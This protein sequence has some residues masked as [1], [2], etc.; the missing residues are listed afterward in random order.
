MPKSLSLSELIKVPFT[1]LRKNLPLIF[2]FTT[3]TI[4]SRAILLNQDVCAKPIERKINAITITANK[5]NALTTLWKSDLRKAFFGE[6]I[7]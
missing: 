3:F 5:I 7:F 2:S 6:L 1:D 4:F